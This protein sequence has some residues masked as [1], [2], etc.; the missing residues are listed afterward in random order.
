MNPSGGCCEMCLPIQQV[1]TEVST[2]SGNM[3]TDGSDSLPSWRS[4]VINPLE[5]HLCAHRIN[6]LTNDQHRA[7]WHLRLGHIN[8][9]QVCNAHKF[10]DGTPKLP[11]H[12]VPHLCPVCLKAKPH[13]ASSSK[14]EEINLE[15]AE[16]WQHV[17]MDFGFIIQKSC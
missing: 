3:A 4:T 5:D 7:L 1:S 17:Q 12:D 14:V 8:Q 2:D 6:A 13:K 11:K 9:P 10:A 15:S 16:C